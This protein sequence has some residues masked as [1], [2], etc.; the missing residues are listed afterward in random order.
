MPLTRDC[1]FRDAVLTS[2]SA[3]AS[4]LSGL[5]VGDGALKIDDSD[6]LVVGEWNARVLFP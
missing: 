4:L 3:T 6:G 2:L 5:V 1:G